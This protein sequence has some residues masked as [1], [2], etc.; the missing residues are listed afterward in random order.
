M[1]QENRNYKYSKRWE[2]FKNVV[3]EANAVTI[4]AIADMQPENVGVTIVNEYDDQKKEILYQNALQKNAEGRLGVNE[5]G[6][7]LS[8]EN[9][10][11]IIMEMA[12]AE[13]KMKAEQAAAAQAEHARLMELK[14][15]DLEIAKAMQGVKTQG[16]VQEI[17]AAG[18][19]EAALQQQ[20][21]QVKTQSMMAQNDQRNRLK[22]ENDQNKSEL[23]KAEEINKEMLRQQSAV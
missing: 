1:A 20:G 8:T 21:S 16:K 13:S 18:E 14:Q 2:E 5:L 6:L 15:M 9:W 3:G 12:L 7:V 4:E 22:M 23:K 11:M 17:N 19:V 10:K